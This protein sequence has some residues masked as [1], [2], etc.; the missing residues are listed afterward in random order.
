MPEHFYVEFQD[1]RPRTA[2]DFKKSFFAKYRLDTD[3]TLVDCFE[4]DWKMLK[5]P[6]CVP[7][8]QIGALKLYM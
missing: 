2:W 3:E 7:D 4:F 1:D 6:K 8:N 5:I